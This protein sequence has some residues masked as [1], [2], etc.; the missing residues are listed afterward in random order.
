MAARPTL[1]DLDFN[2]A[3]RT[4]N[5]IPTSIPKTSTTGLG[6]ENA[7]HLSSSR[8]ICVEDL[9]RMDPRSQ[10][11]R[12]SHLG[13]FVV[14]WDYVLKANDTKVDLSVPIAAIIME[15]A[16]ITGSIRAPE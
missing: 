4:R 5:T 11:Q 3:L 13:E 7:N 16:I 12:I 1:W 8:P 14:D 2:S 6:L 10:Q 15:I 9:P